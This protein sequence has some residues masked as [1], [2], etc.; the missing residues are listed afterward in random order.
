MVTICMSG[1]VDPS[2]SPEGSAVINVESLG[3][4]ARLAAE[5]G[6]GARRVAWV[7]LA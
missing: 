5:G 2:Q 4:S 1:R 3:G 6:P 7:E